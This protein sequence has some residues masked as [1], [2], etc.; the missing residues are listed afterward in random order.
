MA[1]TSIWDVKDNLKRV[2]EY[3]S[4]PLKTENVNFSEYEYQ[5]LENVL[6]Y[7]AQD[8]KTEKQFYVSC[9]NCDPSTA[10][11]EMVSTKIRF[12][13]EEGILAYHAYQ[14]FAPNEVT[15]ETAHQ[16]GIELAKQMWGDRFEVQISTHIDK[17]HF[18]NHFVINSVSFIDGKRYLDNKT[19]YRKIRILSDNLCKQY[20][21]SVIN[22]PQKSGWHYAEW[23]A[24]KLK[25]PTERSPIREDVDYAIS[26][27]MT[28]TQFINK[29]KQMGYKVK[30]NVKYVAVCPPGKTNYFRLYKL[31]PDG[32]YDEE[33]IKQRI[34]E[35]KTIRYESLQP[36]VSQKKFIFKGNLNKQKKLKG[37]RA[38]YFHYLYL[39]GIL[40]KNN[41][42]NRRVHFL[43]KEELRYMDQITKETILLCKE[44]I[45]TIE[46]L[47][48]KES[49]VEDKLDSLIKE[50][51]CT[52]NKI[53]RCRNSETKELL[54]KDVASL[55]EEI[56]EIRKE[57]VLYE[58]IR[59]RSDLMK[60]KIH[61]V[62]ELENVKEN[63]KQ[64]Q[65]RSISN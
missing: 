28:Y 61:K 5:G 52:Y 21:L 15:A 11:S 32:S 47:D 59:K 63:E 45:D 10:L 31:A 9:L 14:S 13:N 23:Q 42:S 22:N 55:S 27:S 18:H 41:A 20:G 36:F 29:M 48:S 54:K 12:N 40:P 16:I 58:N 17:D 56:K 7:T 49:V 34:L 8:I 44:R 33:H 38:L 30:T 53:R 35:N 65:E 6:E 2:L 19:N 25:K 4:N 51:K 64:K 37:F 26:Q 1:T 57:V 46:D 60:E 24:N 50:R 62:K 3:T 43:F 39:M